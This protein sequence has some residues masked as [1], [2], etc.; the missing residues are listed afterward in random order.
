MGITSR[1]KRPLD[2]RIAH[3]RDASLVIIATEGE[4]TEKQYFES[5][6]FRNRRVQV[7]VL[8]TKEGK[9]APAHVVM[10][11]REF[12]NEYELNEGDQLWL[13]FDCDRWP[14]KQLAEVCRQAKSMRK[15]N[16]V[17]LGISNPCFELWL[18][19]HHA[20][21]TESSAT[22]K[23]IESAL[24]KTLGVYNKTRLN[25]EDYEGRI[26]AAIKR[27][28]GMVMKPDS[29]WPENPGTHVHRLVLAIRQL[30]LGSASK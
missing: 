10:R 19:L 18:F 25:P 7:K 1:K 24:R 29:R 17:R 6:L 20:D 21:W 9:S 4:K 30:G 22:S 8:E 28:E 16:A 3:E 13:V 5:K 2:R 26:E 12:V 14:E 15:K 27:A 23:D 11:L